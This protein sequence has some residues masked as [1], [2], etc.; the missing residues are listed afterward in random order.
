MRRLGALAVLVAVIAAA[1]GSSSKTITQV[2]ATTTRTS[3]DATRSSFCDRLRADQAAFNSSQAALTTPTQ[4]E[5]H[6]RNLESGLNEARALAPTAIK[7]DMHTFV[8]TLDGFLHSL[9]AANYEAAR[10]APTALGTLQTPT[11]KHA[12]IGIDKYMQRIGCNV[13]F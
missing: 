3:N 4:L 1:C 2:S 7:D 5:T 6:Y 12:T 8:T 13:R 9:A 11:L 10:L